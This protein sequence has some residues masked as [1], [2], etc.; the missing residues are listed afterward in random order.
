MRATS[1]LIQ[2]FR[3]D[4]PGKSR[5]DPGATSLAGL[6]ADAPDRP[7]FYWLRL[8]QFEGPLVRGLGE[9]SM[10]KVARYFATISVMV[11]AAA[12]L[13]ACKEAPQ[14]SVAVSQQGQPF[15]P[16]AGIKDIMADMIDPAADFL[17]ESVSTDI[18]GKRVLEKRPSS[19]AEWAQ[20]RRQAIILAESANLLM[21]EGRKVAKEDEPLDDSGVDGNLSAGEAEKKISERRAE[22]ISNAQAL[23][24]AGQAFVAAADS[25]DPKA[26]IDAGDTLDQVCEKCHLTFWYPGQKIPDFPVRR[27][28]Q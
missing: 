10:H 1:L 24:Y 13:S 18:D 21:I 17:W 9:I 23:H 4:A 25:K 27:Q 14:K 2:G 15:V 22:F 8:S 28:H 19:P 20:V 16:D 11:L 6:A 7:L 5:P 12:S 3:D 26:M